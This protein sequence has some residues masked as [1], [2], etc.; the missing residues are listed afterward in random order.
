MSARNIAMVTSLWVAMGSLAHAQSGPDIP[1][2]VAHF[3]AM[4]TASSDVALG[5]DAVLKQLQDDEAQK[6]TLIEWLKQA[7]AEAA[8]KK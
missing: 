7:Q 6:A 2:L 3:R 4:Q 5:L 1:A 8:A